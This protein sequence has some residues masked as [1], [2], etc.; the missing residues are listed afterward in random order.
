MMDEERMR[1]LH[2][3]TGG[4]RR[5][6]DVFASDLAASLVE[7]GV[8]QQVAALRA[9]TDDTVPFAA[10]VHALT[11]RGRRVPGVNIDL[12]AVVSLGRLI[13]R[14]HPHVV[15]VHGGETFKHALAADPRR[16]PPIVYR[17]I[18]G[19][20]TWITRGPRRFVHAQL[21]RRASH[22][23]AVSEFVRRQT[24]EMFGV[25][26]SRISTIPNGVSV[27]RITPDRGRSVIRT[28]L[29]IAERAVVTLSLGALSWEKDPMTQVEILSHVLPGHPQALHVFAGDGPLRAQVERTL[30]D[31][32][33]L[34]RCRVLGV[35]TDVGDVLAA[36]DIL[37]FASRTDGMEGMPA[38]V[39]EAGMAGIP[40]V[41]FAVAG[42]PEVVEDS[43]TGLLA[44]QGDTRAL[45]DNLSNLIEDDGRRQTM[46]SVARERCRTRF[47][48]ERI[49][50]MY[51][52]LYRQLLR[53]SRGSGNGRG[54]SIGAPASRGN[55][56]G[57][58]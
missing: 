29:R 12:E 38:T 42:V 47:D 18:G 16:D 11:R 17:R 51:L 5:G 8:E 1:V 56:K 52:T 3:I 35:R 40:V 36:C 41:G 24:I 54:S 34:E 57:S 7:H 22:I 30:R 45:S 39:I 2:V 19:A 50:S 55:E 58:G 53:R 4:Q 9:S 15:Q 6:G 21:M 14:W 43:V 44:Q 32:D 48:I 25:A 49:G 28:E 33:L 46:G 31:R 26:P 10:P 20:P 23:V 27:D 13:G 37:L